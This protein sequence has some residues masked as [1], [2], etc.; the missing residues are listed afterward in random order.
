MKPSKAL[1][2]V[3]FLFFALSTWA[4]DKTSAAQAFAVVVLKTFD[5]GEFAKMYDE[6]FADN[7]KQAASKEQWIK[8][9]QGIR[10]QRGDMINR[11]LANKTR[12]MGVFRFIFSTQCTEGKV[13]EDITVVDM[14]GAWKVGGFYVR[15][16]LE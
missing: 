3:C 4:Q 2:I 8:A 9:A 16:N 10:K 12:S 1:S 13:F 7:M 11:T 15:P 5:A 14:G 6:Q